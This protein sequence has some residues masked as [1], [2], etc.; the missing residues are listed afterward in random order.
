MKR[1]ILVDACNLIH[2]LP[3]FR[4]QLS[5]GMDV[6]AEQLMQQIRILHDLEHWEL[7]VI[8][9]GRGE[10]MDQQFPGDTR[11]LSVIY[12]AA[13][14]TA[15]TI[16][17]TWLMRL[18]KGW[19]VKVASG[20]R[21]VAHSAIAHGADSMTADQLMDWSERVQSRFS[22]GNMS[23]LRKSSSEFGNRLEG[24]S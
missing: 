3:T 21:A 4:G 7:H 15:D 23:S 2:R 19:E 6:L 13:G 11:T 24:L 9:D 8:V 10:K 18:G 16:I 14:Q 17:E 20:D 1:L 5:E 22:R 12:S